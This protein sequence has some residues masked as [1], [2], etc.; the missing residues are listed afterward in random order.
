[1]D[2]IA[3][4]IPMLENYAQGDCSV[5]NGDG[6]LPFLPIDFSKLILVSLCLLVYLVFLKA[7]CSV[8]FCFSIF[9]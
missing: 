8:P 3:Q 1:M 2:V 5:V 4:H 6:Y 7:Q 9:Q